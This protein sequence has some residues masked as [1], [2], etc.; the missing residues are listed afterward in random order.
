MKGEEGTTKEASIYG[1][2]HLR[3]FF[4]VF[5]A[6]ER[7]QGRLEAQKVSLAV[8]VFQTDVYGF[9]TLRRNE[10]EWKIFATFMITVKQSWILALLNE[11]L[12]FMTFVLLLRFRFV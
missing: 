12:K 6:P 5:R 9:E 7:N 11:F 4:F 10:K 2:E 1:L 8:K 3:W